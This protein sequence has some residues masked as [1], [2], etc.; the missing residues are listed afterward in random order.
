M[1]DAMYVNR[2]GNFCRYKQLL[3]MVF[4]KREMIILEMSSAHFT[5]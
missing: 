4:S 5:E 3:A 1:N 2:L